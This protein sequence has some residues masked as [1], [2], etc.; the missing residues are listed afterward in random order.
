MLAP[1]VCVVLLAVPLAAS[2][3]GTRLRLEADFPNAQ[4]LVMPGEAA[5]RIAIG[6]DFTGPG[7][8][9]SVATAFLSRYGTVF[10]LQPVDQLVLVKADSVVTFERRRG[11]V[12]VLD[13]EVKVTFDARWHLTM[14][15]VGRPLPVTQGE[16]LVDVGHAE[17][18]AMRGVDV[19]QVLEAKAVWRSDGTALRPRYLVRVVQRAPFDVLRAVIDA[20]TGQ[21]LDRRSEKQSVMGSVYDV[22]PARSLSGTCPNHTDC[23]P[24]VEHTLGNLSSG[25]TSLNGPNVIARNCTGSGAGSSCV[26]TA[27][28]N[29]SG[30]FIETPD[31]GVNNTDQFG[32]V[33]TYY[34]VDGVATWLTTLRTGFKLG[35]VDALTNIPTEQEY[36]LASGPFGHYAIELG[37]GAMVDWAYDSDIVFHELGHGVVQDTAQ[38]GFYGQD[39]YGTWGEG[40][41]L[42]EGSADC[43]SVG[44][45][46]D[47]ILGDFIGPAL[48]A[49][50]LIL[51]PY[52]RKVDDIFTCHGYNLP[53][54]GNP[55]RFGEI[56]DDGRILGSFFWALH[57]RVRTLQPYAAESGLVNALASLNGSTEFHEVALALQQTMT[58]Q[59]G[60][61]AGDLVQCLSCEHDIP[62]C[63]T[64][65]RRIYAGETHESRLLGSELAPAMGNGEMPSTFQ[66]ELAVPANQ[67]VT[68]DRFAIT[69]GA[70]PKLYARF[71]T[72]VGWANG[73]PTFDH[74]ITDQ[75]QTLPA[76][77]TAG[78]WYLQ[79]A[80]VDPGNC[81]FSECTRRFGIRAQFSG[82][83]TRPAIPEQTCS[84]GSGT[85]PCTCVPDCT[86]K[87]CGSD[88][89]GGM[90]GSACPSGKACSAA[91]V[92]VCQGQCTGRACGDI[93][94][95]DAVRHAPAAPA[96]QRPAPVWAARPSATGRCAGRTAAG[97]PADS[98]GLIKF[99][100]SPRVRV[101]MQGSAVEARLSTAAPAVARQEATTVR[102]ATPFTAAPAG[103]P[104][105]ARR[106]R[107]RCSWRWSC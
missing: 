52:I 72:R 10:G 41:S 6:L 82:G 86:G 30:D 101:S 1:A 38:F 11:G 105:A 76:Q 63:D 70:L 46:D 81:G 50:G 53:D 29:G 64:H 17:G 32:E 92:C 77:T 107:W 48:Q 21:L 59:Y 14:V 88:G 65:T 83:I 33:M 4:V 5:A 84:L 2:G 16:F 69:E 91:G 103:A 54:A 27:T 31:Y 80:A 95:R 24:V 99:A 90:C 19:A 57:D 56:H 13:A 34:Q 94:L 85:G 9:V 35:F 8:S 40:G 3:P 89:C 106:V 98:A 20:Q 28:P 74:V 93:R 97:N 55:G 87:M 51:T 36:F 44:F 15:H 96:I 37:Q 66:Y 23:A 75:G 18:I 71:N 78:T 61:P 100:K 25:A 26:P 60:Q 12:P 67:V 102:A 47:A 49:E 39:A 45:S 73:Q 68:F 7:D 58:S 22:S 104:R 62:G 43:L 42:N 79:G